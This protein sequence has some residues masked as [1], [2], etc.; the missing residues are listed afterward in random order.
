M[1]KWVSTTFE[2]TEVI[3]YF[4]I[5]EEDDRFCKCD[6]CGLKFPSGNIDTLEEHVTNQHPD[7]IEELER[8]LRK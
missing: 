1:T 6:S 7:V 3:D 2:E 5:I 8:Q 4:T